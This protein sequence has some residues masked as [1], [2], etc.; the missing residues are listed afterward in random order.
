MK[1][2]LYEMLN[3]ESGGDYSRLVEPVFVFDSNAFKYKYEPVGSAVY[4]TEGVGRELVDLVNVFPAQLLA[5]QARILNPEVVVPFVSEEREKLILEAARKVPKNRRTY[6]YGPGW[7]DTQQISHA[8]DLAEEGKL[9]VVVSNDRDV[10][11]TVDKIL[12]MRG[13]LRGNLFSVSVRKH[14]KKIYE[15]EL[16]GLGRKTRISLL[17]KLEESFMFAA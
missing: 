11:E 17:G 12:E 5:E 13:D 10:Y 9:A 6:L 14:L 4:F 8:I 7:V 15:N 2:D 3:V 1:L 16:N